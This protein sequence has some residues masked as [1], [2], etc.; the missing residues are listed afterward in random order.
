[1]KNDSSLLTY[2]SPFLVNN[3]LYL[4]KHDSNFQPLF[5]EEAT[6]SPSQAAEVAKLCGEDRFCSFDVAAT[7]HLSMGNATKVAHQQHLRHLH[8]LQ[9]GEGSGRR[10]PRVG[11]L[12]LGQGPT[13]QRLRAATRS[14][15]LSPVPCPH[16]SGVLRLAGPAPKRVQGGHPVP[17][18][19]HRPLPLRQRLQPGRGGGQHLPGRRHVVR[20][21]PDLPAR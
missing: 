3:F 4:P 9:P 14:W 13:G 2:D 6:L 19:L 21:H 8:S 16:P 1:M 20:V 11:H 10:G 5:P 12:V 7:G 18:G 17:D 15:G